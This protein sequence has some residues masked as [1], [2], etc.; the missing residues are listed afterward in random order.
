MASQYS[1]ATG[2]PGWKAGLG[3]DA[4]GSVGET[5]DDGDGHGEAVRRQDRLGAGEEVLNAVVVHQEDR[6]GREP[7]VH[8]L[9]PLLVLERRDGLVALRLEVGRARP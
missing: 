4:A 1:L 2:H 5:G 8:A 6:L 9:G 3:A 7:R